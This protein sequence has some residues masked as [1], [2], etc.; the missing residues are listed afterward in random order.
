MEHAKIAK[1]TMDFYKTTFDNTYSTLMT[2]QAQ[3]QQLIS[4]QLEQTAGL[5]AEGKQIVN[6]WMKAYRRGCE[7]FKKVVDDG[8]AKFE[9][10]FSTVQKNA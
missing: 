4:S 6:E 9:S 8:F 3:T 2:L 1:Q 7:D 5:P 10:Y